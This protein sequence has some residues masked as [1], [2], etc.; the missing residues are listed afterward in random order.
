MRHHS[1]CPTLF[2]YFL[3][4]WPGTSACISPVAIFHVLL[5]K[6]AVRSKRLCILVAVLLEAFVTA[7]NSRRTHRGL[8]LNLKELMHGRIKMMTTLCS[9]WAHTPTRRCAWDLTLNN[10]NKK[11]SCCPSE[12]TFSM[13]PTCQITARMTGIESLGWRLS[14]HEGCQTPS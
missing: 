12:T 6:I 4:L 5:F 3:T 9:A 13:L 7:F 1:R 14:T 10:S 8:G 11:L 2:D